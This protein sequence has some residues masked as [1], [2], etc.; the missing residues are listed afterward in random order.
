M[1]EKRERWQNK[2]WYGK[3]KSHWRQPAGE[4][5]QSSHDK[6]RS[7]KPQS[8]WKEISAEIDAGGTTVKEKTNTWNKSCKES[9]KRESELCKMVGQAAIDERQEHKERSMIKDLLNQLE[10]RR[11]EEDEAGSWAN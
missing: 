1:T 9:V 3:T 2:E 6:W 7:A 5:G 11:E 8:K 4:G 10:K